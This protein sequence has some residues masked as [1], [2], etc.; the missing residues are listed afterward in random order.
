MSALSDFRDFALGTLPPLCRDRFA[1]PVR[2]GFRERLD[3]QGEPLAL[4][5]RRT[6]VQCR[7]LYVLSHAALLGD[8]SGE[9]AAEAG[10]QFL[11]RHC[12][13]HVRGGWLFK[14]TPDGEELDGAKDFYTHA[15]VL[16]ALAYLH[17]AFAAPGA[18][19]LA[20]ETMDLLHERLAAPDGGF[21]NR[22]DAE[23]APD[24]SGLSQNP[25]MHLLE[26]V[27]ALHEASGE[28][29]WF[30]DAEGLVALFRSHLFD[31]ATGTLGEHFAADWKPHAVDGHIVEPGHCFEWAWLLERHAAAAGDASVPT[32]ARTLFDFAWSHG[33]GAAGIPDQLDRSGA[34]LLPTRR[35]WPVCEGIKAALVLD[36]PAKAQA[37]A[38]HLLTQFLPPERDRWF[39]TLASDGT[40]TQTELPGS[41][42]YHL[43]LAGGEVARLA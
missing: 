27:L 21:W 22:A 33:F 15:F 42:A 17:R 25:H 3:A 4:G 1:D 26:A 43:F 37:L 38:A 30:A 29:R 36:E 34:V 20:G 32:E 18:L 5:Y 6:M 41:T 28:A 40:V 9:R 31:P 19:S 13:D 12:R 7:Q 35:I 8:R 39:E 16:F 11:V 10:Y 24:R 2:G 23:W 14:V